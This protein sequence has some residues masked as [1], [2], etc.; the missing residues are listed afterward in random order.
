MSLQS[1]PGPFGSAL[2]GSFTIAAVTHCVDLAGGISIPP[3]FIFVVNSQLP[4]RI[5]EA[6]CATTAQDRASV[7][8][9]VLMYLLLLSTTMRRREPRSRRRASPLQEVYRPN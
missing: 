7:R 1:A 4:S 9:A 3:M 6:V 8:K 5:G 2:C